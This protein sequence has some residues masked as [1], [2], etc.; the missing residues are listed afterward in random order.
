MKTKA[1]LI[2]STFIFALVA[3]VHLMRFMLGWSAQV[4]T[5]SVPLWVS[6]LA[7]LVSAGVAIWDFR[8]RG[9]CNRYFAS[10]SKTASVALRFLVRSYFCASA[11]AGCRK[12]SR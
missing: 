3:V 1:Y 10:L 5:W 7:V 2:V 4:G 6:M 12:R 8:S 11:C 9:G